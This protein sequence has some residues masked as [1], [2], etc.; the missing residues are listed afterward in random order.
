M[1]NSLFQILKAHCSLHL[2]LHYLIAA[3]LLLPQW[4]H[5]SMQHHRKPPIISPKPQPNPNKKHKEKSRNSLWKNSNK[6]LS[7]V[8]SS[9]NPPEAK[10]EMSSCLDG[11]KNYCLFDPIT[12]VIVIHYKN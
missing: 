1:C 4:L 11:R 9:W 2:Y 12:D 5:F 8:L 3:M 6:L 10:I 7:T